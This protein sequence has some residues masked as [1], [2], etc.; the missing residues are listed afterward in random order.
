MT[1]WTFTDVTTDPDQTY[2]FERN[3]REMTSPYPPRGSTPLAT[4]V[5]GLARVV[6]RRTSPVEWTFTGDVRT[7]TQYDAL[8]AWCAKD[9]RVRVADHLGRTWDALLLEFNPTEQRPTRRTAWRFSYQIRAL[10]YGQL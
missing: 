9:H 8:A 1:R 5:D 4:T 3:P 10:V 7:Q 2:Q 6:R